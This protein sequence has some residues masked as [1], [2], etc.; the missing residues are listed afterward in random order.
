VTN[1]APAP[2]QTCIPS[3]YDVLQPLPQ[4]R[5]FLQYAQLAGGRARQTSMSIWLPSQDTFT[6]CG[7]LEL[8]AA[9]MPR[10][11]G[12]QWLSHDMG[13]TNEVCFAPHCTRQPDCMHGCNRACGHL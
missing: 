5:T 11:V 9:F 13:F 6:F 4:Y 2:S 3:P 10:L 12:M 7:I 1:W 8:C